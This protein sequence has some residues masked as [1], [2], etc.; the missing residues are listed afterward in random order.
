M[1]RINKYSQ[2]KKIEGLEKIKLSG[3]IKGEIN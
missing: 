1:W 3:A 2:Q